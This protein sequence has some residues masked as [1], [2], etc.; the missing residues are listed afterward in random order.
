[1]L[2]RPVMKRLFVLGKPRKKMARFARAPHNN[3]NMIRISLVAHSGKVM[4]KMV[5]S[6]LSNHSEAKR[7]LPEEQC[8]FRPARS[9]VDMLFV[10][11]RL[12]ELGRARKIPLYMCFMDLQKFKRMTLSTESCCGRYSHISAHQRNSCNYPP[13]P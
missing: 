4:L 8:D 10:V 5:A 11:R 9:T 12:Q 13:V 3:N 1:M 6:R 2:V 7:I